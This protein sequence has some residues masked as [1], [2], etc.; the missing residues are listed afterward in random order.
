M[1]GWQ[2]WAPTMFLKG[3]HLIMIT[4]NPW[5]YKVIYLLVCSQWHLMR[6]S[7]SNYWNQAHL[8]PFPMTYIPIPLPMSLQSTSQLLLLLEKIT[9]INEKMSSWLS[10]SNPMMKQAKWTPDSP[11]V[12]M[13][14]V[15][16][17]IVEKALLMTTKLILPKS[18]IILEVCL[19]L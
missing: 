12:S 17:C 5:C 2:C 1:E 9:K 18:L 10:T 15:T 14:L 16:F 6:I 13:K 4:F 19:D 7:W 3:N 8:A 11:R